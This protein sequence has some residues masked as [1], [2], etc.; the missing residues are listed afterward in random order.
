MDNK[1]ANKTRINHEIKHLTEPKVRK[2]ENV[3][4]LTKQVII[5]KYKDLEEEFKKIFTYNEKF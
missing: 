1:T 5:K 2:K 4:C 3:E